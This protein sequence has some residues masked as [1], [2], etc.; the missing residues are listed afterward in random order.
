MSNARRW[1]AYYPSGVPANI[2]AEAYPTL[3]KL[4][5]ECFRKYGSKPAFSCLGK[6][7]SFKQVDR[8]SSQFGAYLQ[9]RGLDKGDKIAIMM[10]NLLQYP[11]ALFGALRAGLVV[12]NTNPLYTQREMHHQFTDAGVKA[13][14]IA[15]N[16]ASNLEK[17]IADTPLKVVI[18]TSIGEMWGFP[19]R[20]IVNFLVRRVRRMVPA[21]SLPYAITFRDA[22]QQGRK[23]KLNQHDGHA[24]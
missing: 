18:T 22:L 1:L 21:Y 3:V 16:F 11:I 24:D 6:E 19:K 23:F 20:P 12:V 8:L 2:D 9:S 15:E 5:E 14:V 7:L 4:F 10:P 17:I 13:I